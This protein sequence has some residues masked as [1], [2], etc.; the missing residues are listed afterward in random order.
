MLIGGRSYTTQG[1]GEGFVMRVDK[2]GGAI[3]VKLVLSDSPSNSEQVDKVAIFNDYSFAAGYYYESGIKTFYLLRLTAEGTVDYQIQIGTVTS[4]VPSNSIINDLQTLNDTK[5]HISF[6]GTLATGYP[7][8]IM[9]I[10][11]LATPSREKYVGF[12]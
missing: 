5:V 2:H 10:V 8:S 11:N 3:F 1:N 4:T 6:Q 7:A 9:S 12:E